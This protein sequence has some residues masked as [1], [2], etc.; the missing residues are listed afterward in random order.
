VQHEV[1]QGII[2]VANALGEP[3]S[4]AP[5]FRIP[6]LLRSNA[7]DQLL[8]SRSLVT[9][10]ADVSGDDWKHVTAQEVVRRIVT[11][12]DE[13]GRGIVLLHDIQ[14]A[15][16]LALPNL[17]KELKTRGYRVVQVRPASNS[18]MV[19]SSATCTRAT[20]R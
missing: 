6:G 10:S 3:T 14:P 12:L 16:A 4:V 2:S 7:V 8:R 19:A 15:T 18:P 17:L 5:F 13:K 11:R 20:R 1:E 9:F